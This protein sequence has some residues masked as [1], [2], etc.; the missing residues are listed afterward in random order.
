MVPGPPTARAR[1][2]ALA[3][4]LT[5]AAAL[6]ALP[7]GASAQLAVEHVR[8]TISEVEGDG[9]GVVGPGE[10]FELTERIRHADSLTP[11]LTNVTGFVS[12]DEIQL[13][14]LQRASS[15]PD[16]A[17]GE[18]ADN[19]PPYAWMVSSDA[20]CGAAY[21][22]SLRVGADQGEAQVP[23]R[24]STGGP[25]PL[26]SYESADVPKPVTDLTPVESALTVTGAGRVK[27]LQVRVGDLTH[28]SAGDVTIELVA[29]SG[30]SV[31]LV[32]ARGDERDDFAG[33]VFSDAATQ[34][35]RS[36]APPFTGTYRPQ[37][38]LANLAG[39]EAQGEWKLRVTDELGTDEG[40]LNAWGLD[41]RTAVCDGKPVAFFEA[42][43]SPV[44]P[45]QTLTL[46]ASG[47]SDPNG[48]IVSYEWDLDDD[49]Q[50]DDATGV[51]P[52]TSFP[53]RGR[54]PVALRV[55]DDRGDTG[56]RTMQVSVT[57]PPVAAL[58]ASPAS[59]LTGQDTVLDA[60]G[61]SDPDG[62]PLERYEWDLDGD[63]AFE[64][65]G[66]PEPTITAQ[67]G[68]PGTR[69]VGV[70][71][72]DEDGAGAVDTLDVVVRNRPPVPAFTHPAP[73][74]A[75]S[76]MTFDAGGSTDP[77]SAISRY[78]WDFDGDGTYEVD[79]GTAPTAQHA[80][81]A[82]G[83]VTVGLR[84]T[85]EH[86]AVETTTRSVSVTLA[87]VAS[88]TATPNPV[89][90]QRPVAFD[91]SASSDADGT[92]AR[93]E[94]DLD[95]DGSFE[96]DTGAVPSATRSYSTGGTRSVRLRV[97]DDDGAQATATVALTAAT[98]RPVAAVAGTPGTVDA[99]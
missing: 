11:S 67:W 86:G 22:M 77:D 78:E 52:T 64:R 1:L 98:V 34:S 71:V 13:I 88:F 80:F 76:A 38:P 50:Y 39:E 49:G 93:Y 85:D 89:S 15:Y 37:E 33:T 5:A 26:A 25:G 79:G 90:L 2:R 41:V 72:T 14:A 42:S 68:S 69:T 7:A 28:T 54:H 75:G 20:D 83:D 94:W 23:F 44:L 84:V 43:P 40:E 47:S 46:D 95:G 97:T 30:A 57:D 4:A 6:G 21:D 45:G 66:G 62:A 82:A 19:T 32:S 65:N 91:A 9:D 24:I 36:A 63:G 51:S 31:V 58:D 70:R 29:P 96:T 60:S 18:E 17:F 27:D 8:A 81:P 16:M 35:I 61:S 99:G 55:T 59:P 3:V 10:T 87:P 92:I 53:V 73:V 48:S 74:L 12:E 56:T